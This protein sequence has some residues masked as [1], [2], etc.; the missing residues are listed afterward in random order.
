M[1]MNLK[2]EFLG[3]SLKSAQTSSAKPTA[4]VQTQALFGLGKKSPAKPG[5][6]KLS[7]AVN[8]NVKKVQKAVKQVCTK[9]GEGCMSRNLTSRTYS[10]DD[11][12]KV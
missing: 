6:Q 10:N 2:S 12:A 5:T 9:F 3:S 7:K 8:K 4:K 11:I 1:A